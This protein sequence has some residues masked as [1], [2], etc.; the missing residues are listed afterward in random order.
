MV[1]VADGVQLWAEESGDPEGSPLLLVMGANA[2]SATWPTGLVT[3]L[4]AHH[5]VIRYDHRD[6]GRSTTSVGPPTYAI[7]DLAPDA[8]AVLDAFGV[9]RAHV[10]G[11]SMGGTLVQLLLLDAAHRLLSATLLAT[12]ALGSGLA[13]DGT[14]GLPGV[15]DRL[16]ELWQSMADDRDEDAELAWRVEHWRVLNGDVLPFDA[17]EFRAMESRAATHAGTWHAPTAHAV[18]AQDGLDRGHELR[19]V[20]VPTLVVQAPEDPINPPPH[21]RHL[22][23]LIPSATLVSVPGMGHALPGSVVPELVAAVTHHTLSVDRTVPS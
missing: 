21:G 1:E 10:L 6:T 4:G 7:R 5:R 18:A 9:D 15:S 22:A 2:S 3:G 19:A 8:L 17:D 23:G 14:D 16:L 20:A 11:M 13:G 12:S